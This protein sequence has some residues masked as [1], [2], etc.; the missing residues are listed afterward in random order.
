MNKSTKYI[1][2]LLEKYDEQDIL[3]HHNFDFVHNMNVTLKRNSSHKLLE[4]MEIEN[5]SYILF[6][7]F[8]RGR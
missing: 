1:K 5:E 6:L 4:F 3:L 7:K 8:M 2:A